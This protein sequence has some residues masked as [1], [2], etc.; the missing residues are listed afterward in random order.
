MADNFLENQR[1]DFEARRARKE[2]ERRK[3]LHR[4]LEAYRRRLAQQSPSTPTDEEP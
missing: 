2:R 4:Y 1:L 3:R